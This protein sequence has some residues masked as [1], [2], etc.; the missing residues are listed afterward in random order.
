MRLIEKYLGEGVERKKEQDIQGDWVKVDKST[1]CSIY[2]E[3]K[4]EFE[5]EKYWDEGMVA[6]ELKEQ[7]ARLRCGNFV[8]AGKKGFNN[9]ECELCGVEE[10]NLE[11]IWNCVEA[12]KGIKKEWVEGV[13]KW[14]G[15]RW[16]SR[17]NPVV[18]RKIKRRNS[19]GALQIHES[20]YLSKKVENQSWV[21]KRGESGV[22]Q[23]NV[24]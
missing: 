6:G 24:G 9:Q 13:D 4:E 18:G 21:C 5:R 16:G 15:D 2:K 14:K 7:W 8:K 1:F 17:T 3:I 12:R 20:F 23:F 19:C 11:H 10:E 22:G